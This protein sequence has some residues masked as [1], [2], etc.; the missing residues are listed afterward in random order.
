MRD[1]DSGLIAAIVG[2]AL[3]VTLLLAAFSVIA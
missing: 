1:T 3:A 2:A